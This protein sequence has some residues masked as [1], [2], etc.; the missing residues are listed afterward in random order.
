ML[1]SL[2]RFVVEVGGDVEQQVVA[3]VDD[4]GDPGVGAIGLVDHE[5][6]GQMSGQRLAQHEPGLR[7]R[8]L[9]RVD[10]QQHAVDHGQ[11]ALHL[12]AEVGVTWGVDD[13]DD[14]D[15]SIRVVAVHGGVLGQ[16]RDAF[17]PLEIAGIHQPVNDVVTAVSQC[18]GLPQHRVDQGGLA[19]VDVRHDGDVAEKGADIHA[20]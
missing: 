6:D 7:Q 8:S 1:G 9:G 20:G 14:C 3:G 15:G 17:F 2:L 11:P 12:T 4:L 13:V 5:D 18:A 10:Q 16:D 19:M